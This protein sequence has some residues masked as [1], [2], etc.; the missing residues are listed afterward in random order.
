VVGD[1]ERYANDGL[2]PS[3][4]ERPQ[5]AFLRAEP[6]ATRLGGTFLARR[7][8]ISCKLGCL[9]TLIGI[10]V[11]RRENSR[12]KPAP[13][14]APYEASAWH[15]FTKLAFAAPE[16]GFPSLLPALSS[17][18]FLMELVRAAPESG[19]EVVQDYEYEIEHGLSSLFT[20]FRSR[21]RS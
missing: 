19:D 21:A 14:W 6:T 2:A 7:D 8:S 4:P 13:A 10:P 3:A 17:Q 20:C 16:S 18:H 9:S 1:L 12:P 15:F 11:P 5:I